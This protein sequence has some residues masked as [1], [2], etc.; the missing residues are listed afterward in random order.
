MLYK[1]FSPKDTCFLA[2]KIVKQIKSGSVI[3]LIGDL[4]TGKTT[5]SQGFAKALGIKENVGS[6]TFKVVS[7]Y[8]SKYLTLYHIDAY[9]L[10]G[11]SDFLNIGGEKYLYPEDGVTL[12]EWAD[13]INEIFD[14]DVIKIT[15]ERKKG[16]LQARII[17]IEGLNINV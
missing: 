13:L 7:E 1:S 3:L 9:R 5:F 14:D 17:K 10:E 12:I 11:V 8:Y 16:N 6:P 2:K 15:F 4:G